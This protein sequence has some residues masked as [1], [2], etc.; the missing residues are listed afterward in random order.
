MIKTKF[1]KEKLQQ[2]IFLLQGIV[3]TS[4]AVFD[5]QRLPIITTDDVADLPEIADNI[6]KKLSDST[7]T[8]TIWFSS[9]GA[10]EIAAPVFQDETLYAYI[11]IGNLYYQANA[12]PHKHLMRENRPVY[13]RRS[14]HD[15]MGMIEF[16]VRLFLRDIIV[17]DPDLHNMVDR[18]IAENLDKTITFLTLSK[19]LHVDIKI[20][21]IVFED[22]LKSKLP[23]YLRKKKIETAKRLLAETD[24]TLSE[25]C[26]KVGLTEEKFNRLFFKTESMLPEEYRKD[27]R[28]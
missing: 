1:D 3:N 2:Y 6:W 15:I 20:L 17:I 19:A 26:E 18:Y 5:S 12:N 7:K 28:K 10:A 4:I 22:E 27:S 8:T 23:D 13:D 25:I 14:I 9:D 21:R 16:G 24:F 11:W